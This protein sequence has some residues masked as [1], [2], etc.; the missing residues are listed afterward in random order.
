VD[1]LLALIV[2]DDEDA[3]FIFAQALQD[4]GFECE[5][6]RTGDEAL[7]R[8][9]G[10]A[11]SVVVLDLEL[12]RVSGED[13]LYQLRADVRLDETCVIVATA[14]PDLARKLEEEADL[15]LL[16]PVG[17]SQLRD[18]AAVWKSRNRAARPLRGGRLTKRYKVAYDSRRDCIVGRI[19]G[20][21]DIPVAKEFLAEL[22]RVIST[23]GCK[24]ILDDMRRAELTLSLGDLY[25]VPRLAS[26]AGIPPTI[27][28]AVLV[29]EKDWS[30]YSFFEMAAQIQGQIVKMFTVPGEARCW[31]MG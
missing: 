25:F 17:Y 18:L 7:T 24:R 12:P 14:Y 5:V 21:L 15:V 20:E 16:K 28:S 30:R 8:L 9:A 23:S 22:A 11:P 1:N 26:E 31:L 6:V 27:K 13:I 19:N 2:E 3:A 29:A 4:A 10:P